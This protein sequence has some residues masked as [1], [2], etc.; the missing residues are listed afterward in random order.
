MEA[1]LTQILAY[2][3]DPVYKGLVVH[4]L[5]WLFRFRPELRGATPVLS[6]GVNILLAIIA[7]WGE[8]AVGPVKPA[9]F[10]LAAV[11][12]QPTGFNLIVDV[13]LPQAIADGTYNFTKKLV[14]WLKARF[15]R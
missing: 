1:I 8:A 13:L 3:Q 4:A 14:A 11:A 15:K 12:A 10:S 2:L 9:A 5:T 6:L 7:A